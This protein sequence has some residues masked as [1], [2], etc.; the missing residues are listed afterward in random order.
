M[1]EEERKMNEEQLD[2]YYQSIAEALIDTIPEEWSKVFL[3][4]EIVEGSQTA[5]FYYNSESS[6]Q[7]V[8]SHDIPELFTFREADYTEKWNTLVNYIQDLW[9][10]FKDN[11]QEPWT[12]FTL[13]LDNE[14]R[15]K[16]DYNYDDLS[17]I[18]LH[19]RKTIWKYRYLGLM[20]KSKSGRK[21]LERYL[22]SLK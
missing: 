10:E 9:N 20:P 13:I 14:G 1:C 6:D 11:E 12:N 15:F 3:Y 21:Y 19:E 8:Y 4:G 17:N 16:I 18:D 5:Y 2:R 22:E 7:L